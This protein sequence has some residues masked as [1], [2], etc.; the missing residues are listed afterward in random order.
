MKRNIT[1]KTQALAQ[2]LVIAFAVAQLATIS[3]AETILRADGSTNPAAAMLSGGGSAQG[4]ETG[5]AA[6]ASKRS[7]KARL[8]TEAEYNQADLV[9]RY[10]DDRTSYVVKPVQQEAFGGGTFYTPFER[11]GVLKL[12]G[13]QP[14]RDTVIIV[15]PKYATLV[16]S[17]EARIKGDWALDLAGAGYQHCIFALGDNKVNHIIGLPVLEGPQ[18]VT[19]SMAK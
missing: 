7:G 16:P 1:G 4:L 11:A 18:A 9:V 14:R 2:W 13:Q 17:T 19:V 5:R 3:R 6:K 10:N 8:V 12:A 15:L